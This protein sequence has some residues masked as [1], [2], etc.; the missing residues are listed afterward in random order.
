MKRSRLAGAVAMSVAGSVAK[1]QAPPAK[2]SAAANE[3]KS[4]DTNGDGKLSAEEHAAGAQRMFDT[5]DANNDGKV[6]AAE[7]DA[8]RERVTGTKAV[9]GAMSSADKIKVIDADGDGALTAAEHATGS[10]K[11]FERMD[12]NKDGFV[13]LEELAAAHSE[14]LGKSQ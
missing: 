12:T 6:T 8:A 11:M 4:M 10:K 3:M 5:M 13:T 14:M 1:A 9:P 7:M 2:P